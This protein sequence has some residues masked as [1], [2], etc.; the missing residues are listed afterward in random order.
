MAEILILEDDLRLRGEIQKHLEKQG[1]G[2]FCCAD[3]AEGL[4][5]LKEVGFD[6]VVLDI[7]LPGMSGIEVLREVHQTLPCHPPLIIITGHGDKE[8]AIKAVHFGAYDFIEKPFTPQVLDVS[9]NRAISEKK[10]DMLNFRSYISA[11][12]SG[13]LT[14]RES[15]VA[16]LAAGGLS[17]E[18]IAAKLSLGGETVKSHMKKIFR[19]LAVTN[20][21]ALASKMRK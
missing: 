15:D 6:I 7:R 11:S 5:T 21:T 19:K 4:Q 3:G 16:V 8:N 1:H 10:Q 17:N 18:E 9:I 12:Q 14:A 20:R 13:E 2:V